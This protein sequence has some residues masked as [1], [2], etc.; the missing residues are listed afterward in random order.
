MAFLLGLTLDLRMVLVLYAMF[1][2]SD[3]VRSRPAGSER[4][5]V[6]EKGVK[7]AS[8]GELEAARCLQHSGSKKTDDGEEVDENNAL[9]INYSGVHPDGER[10]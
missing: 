3:A 4:T 9:C 2:Q 6:V 5:N 8:P 1:P 10:K 7:L